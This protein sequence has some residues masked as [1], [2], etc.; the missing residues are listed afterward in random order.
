MAIYK[1]GKIS[2]AGAVIE[3]REHYYM[4]GMLDVSAIVWDMDNHC[5]KQIQVGYYG[6]DGCNLCGDSYADV[7]ISTEVARDIIKTKKMIALKEFCASVVHHKESVEAGV[8]AEVVRGRK[9]PKGTILDIF[10]VG[11]RPTYRGRQCPW[12]NEYEDIAGA[13]DENG[14]KVWI[15]AEYLKRVDKVKSPNRKEREKFVKAWIHNNISKNIR[16]AAIGK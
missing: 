2:Y 4:D 5:G 15:K 10:W 16:M 14:N 1:N 9:I 8:R 7:E 3:E 13:Y 11:E 12:L 6:S